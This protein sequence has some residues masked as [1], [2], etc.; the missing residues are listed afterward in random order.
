MFVLL[1]IAAAGA[2]WLLIPSNDG[3]QTT[4][5]L[6]PDMSKNAGDI[7]QV[8]FETGAGVV[9]EGKSTN[10]GWQA[11]HLPG[12][13]MYPIDEQM[14][15]DFVQTLTQAVL[16]ERK[17]R[18]TDYYS[19]LGVSDIKT[20]DSKATLVTVSAGPRQWQVLI[21]N[22]SSS[23][24]GTY[25]RKPGDDQSWLL[26][27]SLSAPMSETQWLKQPILDLKPEGVTQLSRVGQDGW[28]I[29]KG[30]QGEW[31][32]DDLPEG[33]DMRYEGVL[34]TYVSNLMSMR[35][36]AFVDGG[37]IGQD[38]S[39]GAETIPSALQISISSNRYGN[40]AILLSGS[41][42]KPIVTAYAQ[43]TVETFPYWHGKPFLVSQ[44]VA[45]QINQSLEDFLAEPVVEQQTELSLIDE[46]E[47]P[48]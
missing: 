1:V 21:G 25:V 36:D 9:F 28:L 17:T 24:K 33:R 23:G 37:Q 35:F 4:G 13:E 29:V 20:R 32:L 3:T 16:W 14:L 39:V 45:G 47:S 34:D 22:P 6:F 46:G 42:E 48:Q 5:K 8:T 19:K 11:T 44:F 31:R 40:I 7:I 38:D 15:S 18:K 10:E 26:D 2:T 43:D 41:E 27:V 30:E 12:I